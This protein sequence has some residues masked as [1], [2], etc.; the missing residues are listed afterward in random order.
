MTWMQLPGATDELVTVPMP[1]RSGV[2][3]EPGKTPGQR[4]LISR[5]DGALDLRCP[6][7]NPVRSLM[8]CQTSFS[9]TSPITSPP[10]PSTI[11]TAATP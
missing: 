10:S 3:T 4:A 9:S 5:S 7:P 8:A 6:A 1:R 11:P 2:V